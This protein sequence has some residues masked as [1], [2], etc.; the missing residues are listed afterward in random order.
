M[1]AATDRAI[2]SKSSAQPNAPTLT[3]GLSSTIPHAQNEKYALF[4]RN[5]IYKCLPPTKLIDN[6]FVT[7]NF[8]PLTFTLQILIR[9]QK[10]KSFV[11]YL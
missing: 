1:S 10:V 6:L 2:R 11:E 9:L 5:K 7:A 8:K 3:C 4:R